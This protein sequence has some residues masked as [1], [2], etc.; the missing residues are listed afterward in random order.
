M[1]MQKVKQLPQHRQVQIE[2]GTLKLV[3]M[4]KTAKKANNFSGLSKYPD[5]PEGSI[6][7]PSLAKCMA[8]RVMPN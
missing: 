2:K 5:G 8:K 3:N 4:L 7:I 1:H 6:W